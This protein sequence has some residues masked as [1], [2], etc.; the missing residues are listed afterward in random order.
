MASG[1]THEEASFVFLDDLDNISI[2]L[3]ENNDVEEKIT[4][5][6]SVQQIALGNQGFSVRVRLLASLE[7]SS[8][9]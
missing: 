7:M 3:G 8:L 6:L 2:L 9:Q 1:R 5:L 4:H